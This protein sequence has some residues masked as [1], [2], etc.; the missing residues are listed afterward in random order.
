MA[1]LAALPSEWRE[2][3]WQ[4]RS[5]GWQWRPPAPPAGPFHHPPAPHPKRVG[6]SL[7]AEDERAGTGRVRA[8]ACLHGELSLQHPERLV[9]GMVDVEWDRVVGGHEHLHQAERPSSLSSRGLDCGAVVDVP[10]RL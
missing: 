2:R 8:I 9:L 5:G 6:Y 1:C 10:D 7:R 4:G 3:V